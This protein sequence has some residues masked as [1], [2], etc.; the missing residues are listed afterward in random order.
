MSSSIT[1]EC[2]S[3][4]TWAG[5][6]RSPFDASRGVS[7][8]RTSA[9]CLWKQEYR[10]RR[11]EV[12]FMPSS[13][14]FV[15][16]A[17]L[18][19]SDKNLALSTI[20]I[21]TFPRS[22]CPSPRHSIEGTSQGVRS[23][24]AKF[25]DPVLELAIKNPFQGIKDSHKASRT[26]PDKDLENSGGESE[27]PLEE[28]WRYRHQPETEE[29]ELQTDAKAGPS[30]DEV[31]VQPRKERR[32]RD[33]DEDE[34][35]DNEEWGIEVK[36]SMLALH[37]GSR[38]ETIAQITKRAKVTYSWTNRKGTATAFATGHASGSS[39][40]APNWCNQSGSPHMCPF[41]SK[42]KGKEDNSV[43]RIVVTPDKH[44]AWAHEALSQYRECVEA[45]KDEES[46]RDACRRMSEAWEEWH[47]SSGQYVSIVELEGFGKELDARGRRA[48]ATALQIEWWILDKRVEDRLRAW[49]GDG[50]QKEKEATDTNNRRYK[51]PQDAAEMRLTKDHKEPGLLP[52]KDSTTSSKARGRLEASKKRLQLL[53]PSSSSSPMDIAAK[54]N[55]ALA[56]PSTARMRRDLPHSATVVD[57]NA[58]TT[59]SKPPKEKIDKGKL[60]KWASEYAYTASKEELKQWMDNRKRLLKN[61]PD[62]MTLDQKEAIRTSLLGPWPDLTPVEKNKSP[63]TRTFNSL[64]EEQR[65][66]L[67]DGKEQVR[68]YCGKEYDFAIIYRISFSVGEDGQFTFAKAPCGEVLK[69]RDNVVRHAKRHH[70]RIRQGY[71]PKDVVADEDEDTTANDECQEGQ[72]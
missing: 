32:K 50:K 46:Q 25:D 65:P 13:Q 64:R 34:V 1:S 71:T 18:A 19:S 36:V 8:A 27:V 67:L 72:E 56:G 37:T 44:F 16:E 58:S 68:A 47:E 38:P 22:V 41:P 11:V 57:T 61:N 69:T 51:Q 53:P 49:I 54:G 7:H 40:D 55:S 6:G 63:E 52:N 70:L 66:V 15:A 31:T 30:R 9:R 35:E 14:D 45:K 60:P 59:F 42:S 43:S 20:P 17:S 21:K 62:C 23:I 39:S 48:L 5:Q 12:S 24:F 26:R 3:S 4:L 2:S 28:S 29:R 10:D 33:D